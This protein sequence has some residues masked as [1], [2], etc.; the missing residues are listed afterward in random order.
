MES[1]MLTHKKAQGWGL[2]LMVAVII[3]VG[4][5]I[6][7]ITYSINFTNSGTR[8]LEELFDEGNTASEVI[9]SESYPGILTNESIDQAKLEQLNNTDYNEIKSLLGLKYDFY[10][11]FPELNIEGIPAEYVGRI[12]QTNVENLIKIT[13]ISVYNNKIIKF[14]LFI[15]K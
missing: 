5:L 6:T 9:L 11:T 7:I 8:H 13:R 2:D 10:F 4:I 14:E 15:W 12:N 1:H 3:F